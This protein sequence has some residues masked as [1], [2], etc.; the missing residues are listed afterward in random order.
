METKYCGTYFVAG[1]IKEYT[2]KKV[3]WCQN[4]YMG[5]HEDVEMYV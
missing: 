4:H 5:S 2:K 3:K 1:E